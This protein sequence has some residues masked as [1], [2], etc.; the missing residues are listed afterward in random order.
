MRR[1]SGFP[2]HTLPKATTLGTARTAGNTSKDTGMLIVGRTRLVVANRSSPRCRPTANPRGVKRRWSEY[3]RS[4]PA[5]GDRSNSPPNGSPPGSTAV[6]SKRSVG[7]SS[8]RTIRV[9]AFAPDTW[10]K[11]SRSGETFSDICWQAKTSKGSSAS[12]PAP[13]SRIRKYTL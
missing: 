5:V 4:P 2:T 3:W 10:P 13:S 6:T 12:V 11:S 8:R 9:Y 7:T 1:R